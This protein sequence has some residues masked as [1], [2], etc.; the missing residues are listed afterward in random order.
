MRNGADTSASWR[1]PLELLRDTADPERHVET[2]ATESWVEHLRQHERVT[3][4]NRAM[5]QR[6]QAFHLGPEPP[7]VTHLIGEEMPN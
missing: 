2:F 1:D 4:E 6:V 3:A 7:K 5:D